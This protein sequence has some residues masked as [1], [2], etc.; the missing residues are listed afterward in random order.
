M[1]FWM[2]SEASD[3]VICYALLLHFKANVEKEESCTMYVI[4]PASNDHLSVLYYSFSIL[5]TQTGIRLSLSADI[6]PQ[7]LSVLCG[8]KPTW[9]RT[10]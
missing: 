2:L 9:P 10:S 8:F 6:S 5:E 4:T 1:S 7:N 3:I